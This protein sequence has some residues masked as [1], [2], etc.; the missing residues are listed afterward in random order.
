MVVGVQDPSLSTSSSPIHSSTPR[1][2]LIVIRL[3]HAG[4]VPWRRSLPPP[5]WSG[6]GRA[7]VG[8]V[9]GESSC[10]CLGRSV[11]LVWVTVYPRSHRSHRKPVARREINK[12]ECSAR[13]VNERERGRGDCIP[14]L[15]H[16]AALPAQRQR[17]RQRWLPLPFP[18]PSL[19]SLPL[20]LTEWYTHHPPSILALPRPLSL[21]LS[22][23]IHHH[24][25][26]GSVLAEASQ[27]GTS[28]RAS[29]RHYLL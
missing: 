11:S 17:Q 26:T 20:H 27:P 16:H 4:G 23:T 25:L 29:E 2:S 1:R 13:R 12:Q 22:S 18:P 6:A 9:D 28:E 24:H 14:S 19:P 7:R 15:A 8:T 21:T 3:E 10:T 5:R